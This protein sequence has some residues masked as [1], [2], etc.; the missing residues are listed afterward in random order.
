MERSETFR[1][2]DFGKVTF[3]GI[4]SFESA[5]C[6]IE[7]MKLPESVTSGKQRITVSLPKGHHADSE[8]VQTR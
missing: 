4:R 2:L 1:T 3:G 5:I 8:D 6:D 7:P